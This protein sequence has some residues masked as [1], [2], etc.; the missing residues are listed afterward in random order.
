[1]NKYLLWVL[2]A[3]SS[4]PAYSHV[5]E[6]KEGTARIADNFYVRAQTWQMT[7]P[8]IKERLPLATWTKWSGDWSFRWKWETLT[9]ENAS[10]GSGSPLVQIRLDAMFDF[11]STSGIPT[12]DWTDM[13]RYKFPWGPR[14][15]YGSCS[16]PDTIESDIIPPGEYITYTLHGVAEGTKVST[17]EQGT[18]D[19]TCTARYVLQKKVD[20]KLVD[21]VINLNGSTAAEL[22]GSTQMHVSGF[23][24]PVTVQI[25]NPNTAEVSVSF[26]PNHRVTS[27]T[28]DLNQQP[29]YEQQIYVR[30]NTSVPGRHEYRVKLIGEFK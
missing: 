17:K 21:S 24:G 19:V 23:G 4:V 28:M 5:F 30:G 26:D 9:S 10:I 15:L 25:D 7:G 12:R 20:I 18:F 27:T 6:F 8:D 2:L 1:M 14:Y 11:V 22:S 13:G 3:S 29:Q 16:L